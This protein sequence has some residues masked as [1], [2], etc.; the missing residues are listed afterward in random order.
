[1]GVYE[2]FLRLSRQE[3]I[4][5]AKNATGEVLEYFKAHGLLED[6]E[7]ALSFFN[8]LI[9][10]FIGADGKVTPNETAIF[11]EVFSVNYTPGELAAYLPKF[12][13]AENYAALNEFIDAMDEQHKNYCCFIILAVISADGEISGREKQLFEEILA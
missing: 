3:R 4:N 10:Y 9:G 6:R 11:N 1:M 13:K 5:V 7:F 12:M 8:S 2:D